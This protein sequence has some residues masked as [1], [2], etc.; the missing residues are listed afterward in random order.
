MSRK[1]KFCAIMSIHFSTYIPRTRHEDFDCPGHKLYSYFEKNI[2]VSYVLFTI[3]NSQ[4]MAAVGI[5]PSRND[6]KGDMSCKFLK[7]VTLQCF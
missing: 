5:E 6:A 1:L 7:F 2:N 3:T 4:I